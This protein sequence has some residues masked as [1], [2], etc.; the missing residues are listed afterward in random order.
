MKFLLLILALLMPHFAVYGQ[1]N[2]ADTSYRNDGETLINGSFE[3]GKKGF[4]FS[5]GS[6]SLVWA[7]QS[8][9]AI[10]GKAMKLTLASQTFSFKSNTTQ[11]TS[12]SELS[13]YV[14]AYIKTSVSGAEFCPLVDGVSQGASST[15]NE[16]QPIIADGKWHPY[17]IQKVFGATSLNYEIRNVSGAITGDIYI[18]DS[19]VAKKSIVAS[20]KQ[21]EFYGSITYGFHASCTWSGTS[22]TFTNF[23]VDNDCPILNTKGYASNP[24]T[25]TPSI[26]FSTFKKGTYQFILNGMMFNSGSSTGS[27]RVSDGTNTSTI[28]TQ[29]VSATGAGNISSGSIVVRFI[30][31]TDQNNVTL[32]VQYM[33]NSGTAYID[34]STSYYP[35]F[36]INAFYYPDTQV[37]SITASN[38]G[39]FID[40]NV[41]GAGIGI[42]NGAVSSYTEIT[43]SNIDLV[44]NTS[45]GSAPVEIACISGTSSSGVNCG[46]NAES[47]GIAFVPP[48]TGKFKIC[49]TFTI[50]QGNL[51]G[52]SMTVFQLIETANNAT[53]ILQEGGERVQSGG[54]SGSSGPYSNGLKVCGNFKFDDV[55]KKTIRLMF[56]KPATTYNSYVTIDR[57]ASYGQRDMHWTV[58]PIAENIQAGLQGYNSTSGVVNPKVCSFNF[59]NNSDPTSV[60]TGSPCTVNRNKGACVSSVTRSATGQYA[61]NFNTGYWSSATSYT[62]TRS[63]INWAG[64]VPTNYVTSVTQNS[65]N[66]LSA[67]NFDS[68][69]DIICHGD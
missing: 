55:A 30:N 49:S 66:L 18:D 47:L 46:A 40:A 64:G 59:A 14:E 38:N 22:T 58:E 53:S 69:Q 37:S 42:T 67:N 8:T 24:A 52:S 54:N 39:W 2:N 21:S 12:F 19:S 9:T 36:S 20:S 17:G 25:K 29:Y 61:I 6:G 1:L 11:G 34:T 10:S 3:Q 41:G 43:N 7:T 44:N 31:P 65:F 16:C 33:N 68:S 15:P 35:E 50:E 28:S 56:E 27:W 26:F 62:C 63:I 4:T 48:K 13:G 23:A 51:N 5:V 57:D 45:K 32:N 60:C